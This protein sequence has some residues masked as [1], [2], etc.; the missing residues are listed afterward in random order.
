MAAPDCGKEQREQQRDNKYDC[1]EL[2]EC[3]ASSLPSLTHG[4]ALAQ[5]LMPARIMPDNAIWG[6]F[7]A[8][9]IGGT[10]IAYATTC[11]TTLPATSVSRKSRPFER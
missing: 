1:K 11:F 7:Q 5:T 10:A 6:G 2:Q 3:K 8:K 4:S 9:K